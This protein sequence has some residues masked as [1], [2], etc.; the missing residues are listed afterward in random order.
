MAVRIR[1]YP[2]NGLG[3]AGMYGGVG[4]VGAYGAAPLAQ[5]QL[6]NERKTN[7]MR[8]EYERALW[9]ERMKTVQLQ[10]AMQY[11]AGS[12]A[13]PVNPISP[14]GSFGGMM[15]G[16]GGYGGVGAA[17]FGAYGLSMPLLGHQADMGGGFFDSLGLGGLFG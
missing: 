3:G 7:N 5:Q 2:Q 8:L 12:Y 1:V 17:G 14:Y 9:Q 11:G 13:Q 4:G 6:Q 15:G 16:M 10:T